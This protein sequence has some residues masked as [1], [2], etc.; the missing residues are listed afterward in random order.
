MIPG[1]FGNKL[2][3]WSHHWVLID[4][5]VKTRNESLVFIEYHL[6]ARVGC[7]ALRSWMLAILGYPY[8]FTLE[9]NM[10][11]AFW[12]FLSNI[13]ISTLINIFPSFL[14]A[15]CCYLLNAIF[16]K[17]TFCFW[18]DELILFFSIEWNLA[19]GPARYSYWQWRTHLHKTEQRIVIPFWSPRIPGT[20]VS[21]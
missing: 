9:N 6:S 15:V 3:F 13:P 5:P 17:V 14:V 11:C 2:H 7:R 18:V 4:I 1:L 16:D 12:E 21:S 8:L 20:Y 19:H 10:F